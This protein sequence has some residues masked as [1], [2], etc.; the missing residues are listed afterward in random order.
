MK[1]VLGRSGLLLALSTMGCGS[2]VARHVGSGDAYFSQQKYQEAVS[3]YVKAVRFDANDAH[4]VRQLGLSYYKLGDLR[5]AFQYLS[6]AELLKPSDSEVKLAL[7]QLYLMDRKPDQAVREAQSILATEPTNAPAMALL[8][9][10]YMSQKDFSKAVEVYRRLVSQLPS[11]SDRHYALGVALLAAQR[12][13][14]ARSEF[15]TAVSLSPDNADAGAQIANLDLQAGR[16]DNAVADIQK[17]IA[18]AGRK[19]KLLLLLASTQGT[20][21]DTAAAQQ[22]YR[23]AVRLDPDKS[24]A[25]LA[26]AD[27]Y[28]RTGRADLAAS[29]VDSALA[30]EKTAPAYQLQGIIYQM[31]GDARSA[32]TSYQR[33]LALNPRFF[34]AAN[35]LA[36]LLS[37]KLGDMR[38]AYD[39]ALAASEAAP[40]DPHIK[41]TFGWIVY[42]LGDYKRAVTLLSLSAEKLPQSPGIQYHLGMALLGQGDT[43]AARQALTKAV[44]SPV[45]FDD[46]DEAKKRL[47]TLR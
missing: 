45:A 35:N 9:S 1:T 10:V 6:K 17:Q 42:K 41:D 16:P 23:E 18:I 14:D 11:A 30:L 15:E 24:E 40:D 29:M 28:L 25:R 33:A 7:G 3:E 38:G 39:A 21:G 31:K 46:R 22:T 32:R 4:I 44:G 19:P 37:D 12:N 13:A 36:V 27:F 20:K 43:A 34:L 26:Q 47:L 5:D 8:A 2:Y